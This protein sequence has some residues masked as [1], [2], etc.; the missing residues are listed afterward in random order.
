MSHLSYDRYCSEVVTQTTLLR[1]A[2]RGA[3]LSAT[4]PTC[5]EWTLAHLLLHVGQAHRRAEYLVRTRSTDF[6][7]P[8]DIGGAPVPGPGQPALDA[9]E[10]AFAAW[11]EEGAEA[12]ARA[13]RE[14]G[15]DAP[16]WTFGVRQTADFWARRMTHETVIHRADAEATTGVAFAVAPEIA[17][18]CL[19]EWLGIIS[20]P[21]AMEFQPAY[22]E[23]LG[24]GRTLHLH[25]TDTAPELTA[26]W[27]VDCGGERI[28]WRRAHEKA[29]VVVRGPLT[30]LLAVF[31]RRQSPDSGRVEILGDRALLEFWLERASF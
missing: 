20:S 17:A 14:S 30:D 7:V 10:A 22:K 4:V 9:G 15:P 23:L 1:E 16:V 28:E 27:F 5:P 11:L 19:D 21:M 3:D 8:D 24:P 13:L 12:V 31:Y 2:I 6:Q 26:E 18:D 25:A 29:A